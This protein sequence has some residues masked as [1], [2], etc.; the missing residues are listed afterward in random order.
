MGNGDGKAIAFNPNDGLL[1]HA[2]GCFWESINPDTLAVDK[3]AS[4]VCDSG[5]S[6][7]TALTHR[8]GSD[9]LLADT[10]E[11]LFTITTDAEVGDSLDMDHKSGGLAFVPP[12]P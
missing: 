1:Y 2:S 11:N 9:F 5:V 6:E 4:D 8:S 3:I 12:Q 10:T 7:V